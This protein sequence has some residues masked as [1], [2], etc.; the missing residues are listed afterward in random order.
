MF[1][2][3]A[4]LF[5]RPIASSTVVYFELAL[6]LIGKT[7]KWLTRST[8]GQCCAESSDFLNFDRKHSSLLSARSKKVKG[9]SQFRHKKTVKMGNTRNLHF[10]VRHSRHGVQGPIIT[11]RQHN[12]DDEAIEG[13][14]TDPTRI[15]VFSH[16]PVAE[17][18][19]N[20]KGASCDHSGIAAR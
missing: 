8:K 16:H 4:V 19:W 12:A 14:R 6:P 11:E 5:A 1:T 3:A 18:I 17:C 9:G 15:T 13:T 10:L 7:I 2:P 20:C